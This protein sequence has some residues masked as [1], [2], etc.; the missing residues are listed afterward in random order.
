MLKTHRATLALQGH[1]KVL[2]PCCP[3]CVRA[4]DP[5][6]WPLAQ[7]R[8]LRR[9]AGAGG[10]KLHFESDQLPPEVPPGGELRLETGTAA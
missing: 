3:A 2:R 9:A 7:L 4:R 1:P 8:Q 6:P 10:M 5:P